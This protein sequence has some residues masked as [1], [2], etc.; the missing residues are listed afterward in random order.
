[1]CFGVLSSQSMWF[2]VFGVFFGVFN[3]LVVYVYLEQKG[4]TRY[5]KK[6][7]NI[8]FCRYVRCLATDRG[9]YTN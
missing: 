1:M 8:E 9:H 5:K 4:R 2:G 7:E 3:V 6:T